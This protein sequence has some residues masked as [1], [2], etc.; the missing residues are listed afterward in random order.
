MCWLRVWISRDVII[1]SYVRVG[2]VANAT[3][4]IEILSRVT[5]S[6]ETS[7]FAHVLPYRELGS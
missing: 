6:L 5:V 4:L 3:M 1:S 7:V 2:L